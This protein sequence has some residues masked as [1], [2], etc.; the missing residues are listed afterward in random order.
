MA[1]GAGAVLT[2]A[3]PGRPTVGSFWRRP[4]VSPSETRRLP[5]VGAEWPPVAGATVESMNRN[6]TFTDVTPDSRGH[7]N[8]GSLDGPEAPASA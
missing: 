1:A 5:G 3:G 7:G 4:V 6:L 8:F 2:G